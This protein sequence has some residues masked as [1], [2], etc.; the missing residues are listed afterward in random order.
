MDRLRGK[1]KPT[2]FINETCAENEKKIRTFA[3]SFVD[4]QQRNFFFH[5]IQMTMGTQQSFPHLPLKI[6][7]MKT[8][9]RN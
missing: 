2:E 8:F 3:S 6:Q 9:F 7:L 1:K 5:F 4:E